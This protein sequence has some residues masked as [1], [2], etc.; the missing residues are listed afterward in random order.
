MKESLQTLWLNT[1]H[2]LASSLP[3]GRH[4]TLPGRLSGRGL[5]GCT[6]KAGALGSRPELRALSRTR[7][8]AGGL[9]CPWLWDPGPIPCCQS[10]GATLCSGAPLLSK[11]PLPPGSRFSEPA[12]GTLAPTDGDIALSKVA[13]S[14]DRRCHRLGCVQ[15]ARSRLPGSPHSSGKG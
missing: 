15:S 1:A 5:A 9:Q 3:W 12:R 4:P 10:A 13:K 2:V 7:L 11:G 8:A 14:R 6:Q